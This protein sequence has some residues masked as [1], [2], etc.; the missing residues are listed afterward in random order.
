M[1]RKIRVPNPQYK[2]V[3][4]QWKLMTDKPNGSR[5]GTL[6][7]SFRTSSE[8]D[9]KTVFSFRCEV[10][11]ETLF[12]RKFDGMVRKFDMDGI[13]ISSERFSIVGDADA[14]LEKHAIILDCVLNLIARNCT[15]EVLASNG[16]GVFFRGI[17]L[18]PPKVFGIPRKVTAYEISL[19]SLQEDGQL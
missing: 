16:A 2:P 19:E 14:P 3:V 18:V 11:E 13:C 10:T 6:D 17:T 1:H 7:F 9:T 8:S 12:P 5:F 15:M 4:V